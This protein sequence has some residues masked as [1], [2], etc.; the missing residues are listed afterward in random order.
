MMGMFAIVFVLAALRWII[1]GA[2]R[3]VATVVRTASEPHEVRAAMRSRP[4][5][6]RDLDDARR[7]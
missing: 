6:D 5:A 1:T 7:P 4:N 2:G 3:G